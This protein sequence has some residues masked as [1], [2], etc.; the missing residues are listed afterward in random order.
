M[1]E[2]SFELEC[3]HCYHENCIRGWAMVGK[4][5]TCP[6]CNEKVSKIRKFEYL[7]SVVQVDMKAFSTTPWGLDGK[8]ETWCVILGG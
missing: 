8:G 1:G 4:K 7:N 5:D 2:P 6:M 3:K